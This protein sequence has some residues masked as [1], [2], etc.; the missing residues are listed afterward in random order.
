MKKTTY[1]SFIDWTWIEHMCSCNDEC[2][3]STTKFRWFMKLHLLMF[4]GGAVLLDTA[5]TNSL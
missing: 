1:K 3:F 5:E 4:R 2:A